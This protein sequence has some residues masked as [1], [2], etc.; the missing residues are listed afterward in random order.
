MYG[1][2]LRRSLEF[3][4]GNEHADDYTEVSVF[5]NA[6]LFHGSE[7]IC[8]FCSATTGTPI[9]RYYGPVYQQALGNILSNTPLRCG[10]TT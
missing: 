1:Y 2:L 9:G 4:D 5:E 3:N 6:S 10:K 8:G 7:K